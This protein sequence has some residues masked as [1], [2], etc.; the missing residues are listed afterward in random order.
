MIFGKNPKKF[1][2][3]AHT[4]FIGVLATKMLKKNKTGFKT[5]GIKHQTGIKPPFKASLITRTKVQLC[6]IFPL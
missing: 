6:V 2:E 4:T 5:V 3:F 1:K